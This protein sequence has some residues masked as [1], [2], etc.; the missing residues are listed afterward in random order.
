VVTVRER[1][2]ET[3]A[4]NPELPEYA[5]VML[6]VPTTRLLSVS[7]ATPDELRVAVPSKVVPL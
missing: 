1:V 2:A 5:A 3:D 7:V 4:A 6:S